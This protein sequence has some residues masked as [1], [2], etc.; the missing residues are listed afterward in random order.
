MLLHQQ[1]VEQDEVVLAVGGDLYPSSPLGWAS[2]RIQRQAN[3]CDLLKLF[4]QADLRIVNLEC[5][6]TDSVEAAM[7]TGPSLKAPVEAARVLCDMGVNLATLANNHIGDYGESGVAETLR[8]CHQAGIATVGAGLDLAEARGVFYRPIRGRTVAVVNMV[9]K[10]F[11]AATETSAGANPFDIISAIE[12]LREARRNAEHVVLVVH[13][14]LA[15]THFPSPGAV[16]RLRFLAE[17]GATAIFRHHSHRIQGYEIW[18]GVPIFYGLGNL[19]FQWH[20]KSKHSGWHEGIVVILRIDRGDRCTFEIVPFEQ[21]KGRPGIVVLQNGAREHS[22]RKLESWSMALQQPAAIEEEWAKLV[23]R[24]SPI[25]LAS[26]TV[27]SRIAIRIARRLGLLRWLRQPLPIRLLLENYLQ[28]EDHREALI[29]ALSTSR[30][31]MRRPER[32]SHPS[33][34]SE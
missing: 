9:E 14:G 11:G 24:L 4:E 3:A 31:E 28:N 23:H 1:P 25:Y 30:Q 6:L 32:R 34:C 8:A 22:L 19:L 13:G 5:P 17:E 2:E 10:E 16:R 26:L 27:R 7:K 21:N 33:R 29:E 20:T 18:H 12:S 15:A